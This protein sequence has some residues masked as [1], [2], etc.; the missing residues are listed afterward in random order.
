MKKSKKLKKRKISKKE[1]GSKP[2]NYSYKTLLTVLYLFIIIVSFFVSYNNIF[3]EKVDLNGDN[4]GYYVLGKAFSQG[5]GY[6]SLLSKKLG[7]ANHY[8]PGYPYVLGVFM[9]F[10]SDDINTL[11]TFNGAFLLGVA[12]M[13]FFLIKQLT[14]NVHLAFVAALLGMLNYYMLKYST[15]IMSE[16]PYT[17]FFILS[18]FSLFRL[19]K[20]K[21][22]YKNPFFY[23]LILASIA[24]LYIRS[25]GIA[26]VLALTSYFLFQR[27]WVQSA[28]FFGSVFFAYLPWYLRGKQLGG[29]SYAK[30]VTYINPYDPSLGEMDLTNWLERFFTNLERYLTIELPN[31]CFGI[32]TGNYN[33]EATFA[34]WLPGIMMVVLI[35]LGIFYIKNKS[36]RVFFLLLF[37]FTSGIL[38][39]WPSVWYGTRFMIPNIP[40]LFFLMI[41]G[42]LLIASFIL[43]KIPSIK[44]KPEVIVPFLALFLL[45]NSI[46]GIE[47]LQSYSKQAYPPAY[48]NFFEMASWC[49]NNLPEGTVVC[50]RKPELFYLFAQTYSAKYLYSSNTGE[51]IKHL[52]DYPFDYVILEQLGYGSTSKYLYPAIQ[53]YPDKFEL[54]LH[55]KNPDTY[56]FKFIP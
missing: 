52:K 26:L 29:N 14:N 31:G 8:P 39:L 6:V 16:V 18:L 49:K 19:N 55:L 3:D 10:F 24:A 35:V 5:K 54:V 1:Q 53:A 51:V 9:K 46:K 21:A 22:F 36:Y 56:L 32:Q 4:A 13:M 43:S 38:L 42:V 28:V 34:S 11:K 33:A 12:L 45:F 47:N 44:I 25:A 20:E 7:Q 37:A 15:I 23:I 48:K 17:F 30:S 50:N 41:A 40:V 2:S 27:K